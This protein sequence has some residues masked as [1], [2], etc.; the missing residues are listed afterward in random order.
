M[1]LLDNASHLGV[2]RIFYFKNIYYLLVLMINWW[3]TLSR[4]T[5]KGINL[6]VKKMFII[7]CNIYYEYNICHCLSRMKY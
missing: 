4:I 7:A 6:V 1:E 3:V 2:L 5:R